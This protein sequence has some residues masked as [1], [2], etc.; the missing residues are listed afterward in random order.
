MRMSQLCQLDDYDCPIY[1][2]SSS[3]WDALEIRWC[4][5]VPHSPHSSRRGNRSYDPVFA[6]SPV[7]VGFDVTELRLR[8]A[9]H[10]YHTQL[11]LQRHQ[12]A[13]TAYDSQPLSLLLSLSHSIYSCF[14]R[15]EYSFGFPS[16]SPQTPADHCNCTQTRV[17]LSP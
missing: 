8:G 17:P 16:S 1:Y 7:W 13:G 5:R 12:T 2:Y 14:H 6:G 10:R 11:S 4:C 3:G 15:T 9:G